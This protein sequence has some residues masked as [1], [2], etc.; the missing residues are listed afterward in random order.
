MLPWEEP[1]EITMTMTQIAAYNQTSV[2]Q[3]TQTAPA[4]SGNAH[5][6]FADYHCRRNDLYLDNIH[7]H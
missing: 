2:A 3:L 4:T 5:I 1:S 7:P 6:S